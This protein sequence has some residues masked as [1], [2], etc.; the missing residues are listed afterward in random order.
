MLEAPAREPPEALGRDLDGAE[1]PACP[2]G[3]TTRSIC[4]TSIALVFDRL[5]QRARLDTLVPCLRAICVSVSP[6]CT[7]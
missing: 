7:R 4:P 5:F 6:D 3:G 1:V 2:A